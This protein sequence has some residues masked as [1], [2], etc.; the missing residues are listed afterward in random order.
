[1]RKGE[2][3]INAAAARPSLLENRSFP[4]KKMAT[5]LRVPKRAEGSLAINSIFPSGRRK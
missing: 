1:M 2:K 3:A 5:M 4:R